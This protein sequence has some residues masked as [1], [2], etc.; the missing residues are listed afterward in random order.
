M[1]VIAS[2]NFLPSPWRNFHTQYRIKPANSF[3][4]HNPSA[5]SVLSPSSSPSTTLSCSYAAIATAESIIKPKDHKFTDFNAKI[6]QFCE[7]G[8]L[9]EAMAWFRTSEKADISSNTYCALLQLCAEL[10]RLRYGKEIH[11]VISSC[12]IPIDGLLGTRLVFMYV[13]CGELSQGRL[14]FDDVANDKVFL[15]NLML[16]EYAKLEEFAECLYLFRKMLD[17]GIAADS[18]TFS[19]ILKCFAASGSVKEG[20]W[21]HGYLLKFGFDFASCSVANS[22]MSFYFKA[23]KVESA[24]KVFDEMPQRDVISWNSM[25]SGYVENDDCEEAIEIFRMM[26]ASG[27]GIDLASAVIVL[28]A[29]ASSSALRLGRTVHGLGIKLRFDTVTKF[30]NVLLDMYSKSGELDSARKVFE[31]TDYEKCVVSWTAMI[32]AYARGGCHNEAIRLFEEM[33]IRPDIFTLS[34]VL[35]ACGCSGSVDSGRDVHRYI[36][37]HGL[38]SDLFV[39]NSLMDMY[40]KCGSMEDASRLFMKM[41]VKDVIAW[42]TI[43]GGYSKNDLPREAI[44]LFATM[45][46]V[47]ARLLDGRTMSCVLPACAGLSALDAGREIHGYILRK[48]YLS[49]RHVANALVDM[50]AKCGA[51]SIAE[52]IFNAIPTKDLVS[53]TAMIAGYGMHGLGKE[54]VEAFRRMRQEGIEPDQVSFISV[55]YACSHSGLVDEGYRF[56]EIMQNECNISPNLEHYACVVDLLSRKGKLRTAYEFINAMPISPDATIWGSLLCGCRIHHDVE[57]AEE[58]S[59]H[60]FELEPENAGYYV[61]MSNI[62]AEAEMWDEARRIREKIG[63]R[64]LKKHPGCSWIADEKIKRVHVFVAGDSSH[65]EIRPIEALLEE[66]RNKMKEE[67]FSPK[68]RYALRNGDDAEK[69]MALCGHSEKLAMA[70]GMLNLPPRT[71]I[72]VFKNLRIC[73][74]CHETAKFVSKSYGKEIIVRDSNFFHHFK[75]GSCSCRGFW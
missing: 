19:C 57:L 48:G 54:A 64:G 60:V 47:D 3:I 63:R 53:W 70:Y 37:E 43:I 62:Y 42:N 25:M 24:R 17:E 12:D 74:D 61:L 34:V 20:E 18:Y 38:E 31:T 58:V 55:L 10:K 65:P 75:D 23:K 71:V 13:S 6:T 36:V 27:I 56:F 16:N 35:H 59:E 29:C 45:A 11:S 46:R 39:C 21:I 41:P 26:V 33:N 7:E 51:L 68:L 5:E 69:E 67:G 4:T 44:R 15:W 73:R 28:S 40:A 66:I 2:L 72:R 9:E 14:V 30:C 22:L 49:D 52:R 8:D 32:Q 1:A 50:Y